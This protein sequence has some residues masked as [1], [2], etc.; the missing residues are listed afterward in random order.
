MM[1]SARSVANS[2]SER[3]SSSPRTSSVCS[4][5]AG[6]AADRTL[7]RLRELHRVSGQHHGP[8]AVA[9]RH[10]DQHVALCDVGVVE[11]ILGHVAR[12]GGDPLLAERGGRLELGLVCGPGTTVDCSSEAV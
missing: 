3:S 9:A 12:T 6:K 1:P 8:V 11:E 10:L 4:P 5:K 2:S 7:G